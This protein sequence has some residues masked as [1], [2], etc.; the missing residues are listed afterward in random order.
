MRD[1]GDIH[2]DRLLTVCDDQLSSAKMP[3]RGKWRQPPGRIVMQA[4]QADIRW[5]GRRRFLKAGPG[6][7][8]VVC[9]NSCGSLTT[10]ELAVVSL[11]TIIHDALQSAT[12]YGSDR[13]CLLCP[14]IRTMLVMFASTISGPTHRNFE[15]TAMQYDRTAA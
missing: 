11:Q 13:Q 1:T 3:P 4:E 8:V 12:I 7:C 6:G 2:I 5:P 14:W 9:L 10:G 15:C